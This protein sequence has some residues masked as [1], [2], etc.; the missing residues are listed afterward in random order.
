MEDNGKVALQSSRTLEYE[1]KTGY[2]DPSFARSYESLR[3]SD[4]GG[5]LY[6]F[7]QIRT[8]GKLLDLLPTE[9][10]VLNLA[11]GTGRITEHLL[12]RGFRVHAGDISEAMLDVARE[13]LKYYSNLESLRKMD[14]EDIDAGDDEFEYTTCIKLMHLVPP[15]VRAKMLKEISRVTQNLIIVSYSCLTCLGRIKRA[16]K[17][18]LGRRKSISIF[19]VTREDLEMELR[20]ANLEIVKKYWTFRPLSEEI[21]LLVKKTRIN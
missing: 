19:A 3:F 6:A 21:I 2:Q 11:C 15:E 20:A 5:K 7:L 1:A 12:Q 13:R 18:L 4:I 17:I 8:I 16:I 14:V 10:K 9:S